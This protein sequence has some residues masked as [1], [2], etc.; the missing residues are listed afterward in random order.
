M[1]QVEVYNLRKKIYKFKIT[2]KNII[3][4]VS[5]FINSIYKINQSNLLKF[6]V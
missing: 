2:A 1:N 3:L 4:S 6:A 5:T